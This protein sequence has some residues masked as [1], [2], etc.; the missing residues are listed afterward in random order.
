MIPIHA[1]PVLNRE[2]LLDIFPR[3]IDFGIVTIGD[4]PK[5]RFPLES[6]IPLNFEFEFVIKKMH[7]DIRISPL[8]GIIPGKSYIEIEIEYVPLRDNPHMI[9][10]LR[11]NTVVVE[12]ELHIS[13]FDFQPMVI[14]IMGS[15]TNPFKPTR[16]DSASDRSKAHGI[17]YG[18]KKIMKGGN[19]QT[20]SELGKEDALGRDD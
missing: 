13:Q 20:L 11:A 17:Q 5:M 19:I 12:A 3:L 15:A 1:Y 4:K 16:I 2:N 9:P 8:K 10:P 7:P 18:R 14:K 6:K